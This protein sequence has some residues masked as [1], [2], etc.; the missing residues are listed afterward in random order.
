MLIVLAISRMFVMSADED[1]GLVQYDLGIWLNCLC[2]ALKT[3]EDYIRLFPET[4][5]HTPTSFLSKKNL[6][7]EQ[8]ALIKAIKL[9]IMDVVRRFEKHLN[10]IGLSQEAADICQRVWEMEGFL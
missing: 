9:A 10:Q 3:V 8:D 1:I 7:S 2:S 4:Q 6:I 5:N